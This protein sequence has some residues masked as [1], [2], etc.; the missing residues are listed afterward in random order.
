LADW[1]IQN[2]HHIHQIDHIYHIQKSLRDFCL[3]S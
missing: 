2:I 1:R 3:V